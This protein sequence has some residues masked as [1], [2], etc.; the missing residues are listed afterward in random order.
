MRW[1]LFFGIEN[2]ILETQ[3]R[4]PGRS[5]RTDSACM[6]ICLFPLTGP[7]RCIFMITLVIDVFYS[8]AWRWILPQNFFNK[9]ILVSTGGSVRI[10]QDP[11]DEACLKHRNSFSLRYYQ[12]HTVSNAPQQ[13]LY[14]DYLLGN[15]VRG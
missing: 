7:H 11:V 2:N 15:K 14:L 4:W 10:Q 12:E 8:W 6:V 3:Y 5:Y 13:R 9:D 1:S